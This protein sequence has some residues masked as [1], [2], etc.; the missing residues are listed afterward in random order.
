MPLVP[1]FPLRTSLLC[2][3]ICLGCYTHACVN[4]TSNLCVGSNA[5]QK[6]AG[7]TIQDSPQERAGAQPCAWHTRA[8]AALFA[9]EHGT[10]PWLAGARDRLTG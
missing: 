4:D 3:L 6:N 9:R 2:S 5:Q 1:N 7:L 10:L 8:V